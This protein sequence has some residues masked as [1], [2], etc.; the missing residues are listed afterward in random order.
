MKSFTPQEK[1]QELILNQ[2]SQNALKE[3]AYARIQQFISDAIRE[4]YLEFAFHIIHMV[5]QDVKNNKKF[6]MIV[7]NQIKDSLNMT[8]FF[9]PL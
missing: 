5:E 1:A 3:Q 2:N 6:D 4:S 9:K 8:R 7:V